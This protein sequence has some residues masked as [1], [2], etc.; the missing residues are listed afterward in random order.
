MASCWIES[1]IG[2][3]NLDRL[4]QLGVEPACRGTYQVI[5]WAP[6]GDRFAVRDGFTSKTAALSW[7]SMLLTNLCG[8]TPPEPS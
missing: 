4:A 7:L 6:T 8:G 2:A 5:G 3:V 1:P